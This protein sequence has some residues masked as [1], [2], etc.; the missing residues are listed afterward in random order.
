VE[1]VASGRAIARAAE[2]AGHPGLDARAVF[3]AAADGAAWADRIIDRSAAAVARL[4]ADLRAMLAIDAVI[5]G[6]SIGLASGY[7][8]RVQAH[9][10]REPDLFRPALHLASLGQDSALYGALALACEREAG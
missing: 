4:A 1:S 6:G 2:I 10:A 3:A 5:I 7:A 9:L 8:G